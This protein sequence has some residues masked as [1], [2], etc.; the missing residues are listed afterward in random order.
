MKILLGTKLEMTQVF[1][2]DGK[3][4]PVTL[5]DAGEV[6]VTQVKTKEKDGYEAVQVGYGK[7]KKLTKPL[8]GH[9]KDLL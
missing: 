5:I 6:V 8:K 3:V 9:M 7:K 1:G 4:T 2:E